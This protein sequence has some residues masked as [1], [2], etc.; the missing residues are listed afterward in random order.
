MLRD[1]RATA[2]RTADLATD[3]K[4]DM[5]T[6]RVDS[7]ARWPRGLSTGREECLEQAPLL[8]RS[9]QSAKPAQHIKVSVFYQ[10]G[11]NFVCASGGR[12]C[13]R[14]YKGES[15]RLTGTTTLGRS[16]DICPNCRYCD[17][18]AGFQISRSGWMACR[19][20]YLVLFHPRLAVNRSLAWF[21]SDSRIG[22]IVPAVLRR[23]S[24]ACTLRARTWM[25]C[26]VGGG[27]ASMSKPSTQKGSKPAGVTGRACFWFLSGRVGSCLGGM[28]V[29]G[30]VKY[31][32]VGRSKFERT[33]GWRSRQMTKKMM[34]WKRGKMED[35]RT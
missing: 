4:M 26:S 3:V 16:S 5:A 15:G 22:G 7:P 10:Q 13:H 19:T 20:S 31:R 14:K 12:I 21:T 8:C 25:S 34:C 32:K 6:P 18:F 23:W 27:S 29:E 9:I 1:L 17:M 24:N 11:P 28:M 35:G 2:A 30:D 33:K